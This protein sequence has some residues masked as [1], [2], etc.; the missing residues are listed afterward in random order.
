MASIS[1]IIPCR[2]EKNYIAGCIESF[3]NS[4][5]PENK[6]EIIV[7]DGLS[8]DGTGE[9]IDRYTEKYS[10]V[11]HILN[12]KKITPAALNKGIK[13]STKEYILIAS[14]H[15]EFPKNYITTLLQKNKELQADGVGGMLITDVKNKNKKSLSIIKVLSN[16]LGVGNSMF[17]I[18]VTKPQ[19]VDTVP[20]G[21][22]K[23][24]IF[25]EIGFYNEALIRNHDME[26]SKRLLKAKKKIYLIPQVSCTYYARETYRQL[27]KNNF[28]NGKWNILTV[29]ITRN[30][31]SLSARHFIP[32][33]FVLS[34]ILPAAFSFLNSG[35][36]YSGL[37]SFIIYLIAITTI[38]IKINSRQTHLFYILISFFV[39]HFSYGAGSLSGIFRIDK[40]FIKTRKQL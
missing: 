7:V 40:I 20:F 4:D 24:T 6:M 18:G 39:L 1:I 33:L 36:I 17:R 38:S 21:I 27:A 11:K 8:T 15:A 14:A 5:F 10:F 26:W 28:A 2:N 29:Y 25:K 23:K 12:K 35:F 3:V 34:L 22:Y 9:I 30:I 19:L 13:A 37:F 16:K 31:S 32:L